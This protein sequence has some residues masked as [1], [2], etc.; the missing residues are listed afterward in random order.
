MTK[1][2]ADWGI[3]AQLANGSDR[4]Y[5]EPTDRSGQAEWSPRANQARRFP[6]EREA[7]A[8]IDRFSTPG[9][10]V[11]YRVVTLPKRSR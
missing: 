11:K 6:S 3:T 8:E 10:A 7:L 4:Y 1:K 2:S 5:C 9:A